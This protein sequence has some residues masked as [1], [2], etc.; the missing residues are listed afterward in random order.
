M[1]KLFAFLFLIVFLFNIG[2]YYIFFWGL[3]FSANAR[4]TQKLDEGYYSSEE[5]FEFKIPLSIPYPIQSTGFDRTHGDFE[6]NGEF[7]SLVKQKLERDTLFIVC[8]KNQKR[9]QLAKAFSE[10]ANASN[11]TGNAT[12]K[13][14]NELLSKMFK[15]FNGSGLL[16][17]VHGDGWSREVVF[18]GFVHAPIKMIREVISPPPNFLFL[19]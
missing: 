19:S 4:L 6:Y 9:Q 15:D 18:F 7:Y 14:G 17:V 11:D 13:A 10:Y 16:E 8:I 1:K 3:Q 5:T 12:S 2:G